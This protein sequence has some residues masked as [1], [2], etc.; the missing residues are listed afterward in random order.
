[1]TPTDFAFIAAFLKERSGLIITPD[2]TYLLE[3]RL[4]PLGRKYNLAGLSALIDALKTGT[5]TK[6]AD[7]VV[8][9]MTTNETS[10]FRDKNP[11]DQLRK[12]IIPQM[13]ELRGAAK[14]LRIWSAA[15]STGQEPYSLAM[16]L[17][18]EFP[19]LAAWKIDIVA[20]DISP[21]VL[22][23]AREGT[24]STFEV[25]RGL[26]I[27]LLVRHFEQIGENWRIKPDLRRMIDFRAANLLADMSNLG[28]F[29]IV[30]CRNVLIYFDQPTK[31]RI[32]EAI[33]R[34]LTPHGAL[35]LGGAESVFG[36]S[37]RLGSFP[38]L[39]GVYCR[40]TPAVPS[41]SVAPLAPI[42]IAS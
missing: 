20:T 41:K 8:D 28:L 35:I 18:D 31:S 4:V 2:K 15:C 29:D 7:E 36:L 1:M 5:Q 30:L 27:Q 26:P 3:A 17:K 25:Q 22:D 12:T 13:M 34:R 39:R 11:F 19:A 23:R 33:S 9:A 14:S 42:R 6:L 40:G 37:D 21:S 32:L 16:M 24:Y 38:G 10:F